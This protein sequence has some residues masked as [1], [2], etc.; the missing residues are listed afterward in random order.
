MN[1]RKQGNFGAYWKRALLAVACMAAACNK[2]ELIT[3]P[4]PD[5][6]NPYVAQVLDYRP[7]VGQFTNLLPRYEAGDT[8]QTMNA[9]ALELLESK[10]PVTLGGYGGYIVVG[11]DHR[12]ENK[13]GLCDFRVWGNSFY[14]TSNPVSGAP[15]GGSCEPGI[16]QV[17]CDTNG[18]GVPD[19]EEWYE[20]AG[21]AHRRAQSEAW[22]GRAATAGNDVELRRRYS[23]TYYRPAA[24]PDAATAEYIRWEDNAG[25]S[26][27]KAKNSF[28]LQ[29]YYPQWITDEK[30]TFTGTCLPQNGVYEQGN[31]LGQYVLYKFRFGYADNALNTEDD[32]AIDIDWAVDAY[33]VPVSL[34]GVDFIRI[35]TGVNQENGAL[36]ECSTE[37]V[38][39][40][41]LHLQGIA[42]EARDPDLLD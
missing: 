30:L 13:P 34:P 37:V 19:E 17:A 2:N 9:K 35:Y 1:M 12:I 8:Q 7:A 39:V 10:S 5:G 22:Y 6:P 41:D 31:T 16:I 15:A 32:S 36:G 27:Y 38:Q 4:D 21:S 25:N 14:S 40:E 33:G 20:I 11:F 18:N 28:H 29:S 26:G 24:E 23:M 42:I 3:R